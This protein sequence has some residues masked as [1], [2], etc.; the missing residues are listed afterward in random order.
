MPQWLPDYHTQK[1][2]MNFIKVALQVDNAKNAS[3]KL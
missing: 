3:F 1:S 2:F